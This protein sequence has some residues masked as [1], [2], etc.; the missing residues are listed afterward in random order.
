MYVCRVYLEFSF[1]VH[2][3]FNPLSFLIMLSFVDLF[4]TQV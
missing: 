3:F 4:R 1:I 2:F